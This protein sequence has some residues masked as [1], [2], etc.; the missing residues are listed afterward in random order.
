MLLILETCRTYLVT[1]KK[2]AEKDNKFLYLNIKIY[3]W[4]MDKLVANQIHSNWKFR[5][6]LIIIQIKH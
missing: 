4:Q 5:G 2:I 6:S 1:F 3:S